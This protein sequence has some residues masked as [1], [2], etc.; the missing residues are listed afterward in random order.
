MWKNRLLCLGLVL[1][2]LLAGCSAPEEQSPCSQTLPH[3]S[4]PGQKEKGTRA[5]AFC[6]KY[7]LWVYRQRLCVSVSPGAAL[8]LFQVS[9]R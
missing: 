8:G 7:F 3:G 4:Q 9:S 2:L 6:L 1:C 5:D